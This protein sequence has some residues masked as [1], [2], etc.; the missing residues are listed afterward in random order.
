MTRGVLGVILALAAQLC[1]SAQDVAPDE[2]LW[3]EIVTLQQSPAS[4]PGRERFAQTRTQRE[5]L[6]AAVRKYE[7]LYPGGPRADDAVRIELQT[8]FEL[9][10]LSGGRTAELCER[11]S[12][13]LAAPPSPAAEAEAA[14][15]ELLCRRMAGATT[16]APD[17]GPATAAAD[18]HPAPAT[19]PIDRLSS[20]EL[21]RLRDFLR[22]Y[23]RSRF[24]PHVA[25]Q[26]IAEDLQ[27]GDFTAA[28][29]L[30]DE[31]RALHAD[32]A[33]V[34]RLA[35][36]IARRTQLNQPFELTGKDLRDGDA[37]TQRARGNT[38]VVIAWSPLRATSIDALRE[39]ENWRAAGP[40]RATIGFVLEGSRATAAAVVEKERVSWEQICDP[41]GAAGDFCRRWGIDAAPTIFVIGADGTLRGVFENADWRRCAEQTE[42]Q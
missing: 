3:N 41:L 34:E 13:V 2:H 33:R 30:L 14:Y 12:R 11:V 16:S 4:Q 42:R 28:A 17:S 20:D 21:E 10:S 1:A 7:L 27:R 9:A 6:L 32:D 26:L 8:L 15:W 19:Q 22:R 5:S 35:G 23:P 39:I 29:K 31:L 38:L 36:R 40:R 37:G 24:A 18:K 25:E